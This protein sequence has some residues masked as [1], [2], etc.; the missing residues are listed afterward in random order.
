MKYIF[1]F[2]ASCFFSFLF[3][4]CAHHRDVRPGTNG[5]HRVVI[6]TPD[7]DQGSQEAIAQ[8]N[9]YCESINKSAAFIEEKSDYKGDISEESYKNGK[10]AT[11][12]AKVL[13]STAYVFGG[14]NESNLGGIVG[15]GGV[16]GDA[17]LGNGY[18]IEM[19]FKCQ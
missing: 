19:K 9:H 6:P 11:K 14:K 1:L 13:G 5:I 15:L 3:S 4:S 10:K 17:V 7:Q 12:V 16:A 2:S 8:A 18:K